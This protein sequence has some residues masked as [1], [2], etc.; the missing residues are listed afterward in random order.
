ML[1][2]I[3]VFCELLKPMLHFMKISCLLFHRESL[4]FFFFHLPSLLYQILSSFACNEKGEYLFSRSK[5]I[6]NMPFQMIHLPW[7]FRH[8]LSPQH[9]TLR[10]L[11][12]GCFTSL[13]IHFQKMIPLWKAVFD[14]CQ[15]SE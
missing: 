8:A 9:T 6:L 11:S 1:V 4:S 3:I 7:T 13:R 15:I 10:V 14:Q 5:I 12:T 2:F